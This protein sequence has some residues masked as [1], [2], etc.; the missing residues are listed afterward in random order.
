MPLEEHLTEDDIKSYIPELARFLWS[1]ETDYSAQKVQA[2][3]EVKLELAS[4]GFNPAKINPRLVIRYSGASAD[5]THTTEPTGED[6]A[7][8]LRYV[9][10]VKEFTE[11]GL[12]TFILEGSNDKT[13][14]N[15]LDSRKAEAAGTI[16]FMPGSS[17]LYYRLRVI[18]TGGAIDYEAYLCDTGTEKLI[19]YKWLELILLDRIT[20]DSDQYHLKMKYFKGEYDKLLGRIKIW[21]DDNSDGILNES[22]F[23][24]TSSIKMLK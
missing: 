6:T 7:A 5:T 23:N 8:R 18:I 22:E 14:W 9:L 13:N 21:E 19:A 24:T 4:R 2:V 10:E 17:F 3:N 15:V 1:E 12:K 11:G 20:Q 16:T